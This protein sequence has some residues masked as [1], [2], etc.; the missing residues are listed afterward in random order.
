[1]NDSTATETAT[2]KAP[3]WADEA[4]LVDMQ[5]GSQSL[6]AQV[7][8][9]SGPGLYRVI[10]TIGAESQKSMVEASERMR[11]GVDS[12]L[13]GLDG[14]SP[15][16]ERL[17]ELST[18]F[19]ELDP[20]SVTNKWWFSWM[21]KGIKRTAIKKFTGRY[22]SMQSHVDTI[23]NGL[24]AGKDNILESNIQSERQYNEIEVAYQQVQRDIYMGETLYAMIEA[25]EAETEASDQLE[26]NKLATAKNTVARRIRDLRT[27]EAAAMQFFVAIDQTMQS[28]VLL[29]EQID[30]ALSVGPMVMHNALQIQS[31]LAQQAQVKSAVA[32][33]QKGLSE[34]M[35]QN[36]SAVNQAAQEIGD[37]YNNPVVAVEAMQRSHDQLMQ[38]VATA[39]KTMEDS[40]VKAREVSALQAS[41]TEELKPVAEAMKA[42]RSDKRPEA[43]AAE[44]SKP[45]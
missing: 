10:D 17:V 12:L 44:L 7:A 28:N 30:S 32:E 29:A 3:K 13:K 23:L 37:L 25:K 11:G 1:M 42:T 24:R 26:V 33:F 5:A 14:K 8:D 35:E 41:M 39:Q 16:G 15:T 45:E 27:K 19:S 38:A 40:T 4:Q 22:A 34:M 31:A 20:K 2:P 43:P 36:A 9:V 18:T 6:M 21:P